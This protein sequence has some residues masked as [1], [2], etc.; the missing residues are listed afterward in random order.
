MMYIIIEEAEEAKGI[1]EG[2]IQVVNTN[3]VWSDLT[4]V[5]ESDLGRDREGRCRDTGD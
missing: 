3:N 4:G 1:F 2:R 5:V